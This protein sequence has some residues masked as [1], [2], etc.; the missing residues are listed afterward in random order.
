[1]THQPLFVI[2][3]N[4]C[5]SGLEWKKDFSGEWINAVAGT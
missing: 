3:T 2:D 4:L 1:M 5:A